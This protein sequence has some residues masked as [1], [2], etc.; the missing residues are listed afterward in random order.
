MKAGTECEVSRK[1]IAAN[2]RIGSPRGSYAI[3]PRARATCSARRVARRNT[4]KLAGPNPQPK[5]E[6]IHPF[7]QAEIDLVA[8]ELGPKLTGSSTRP[9]RSETT[10]FEELERRVPEIAAWVGTLPAGSRYGIVVSASETG[11]RPS[12][13]LAVHFRRAHWKTTLDAAGLPSRR[14]YDMRDS[15]AT[16]AL[17]VGLSIFDL[18]RYMGHDRGDDRPH[19]RALGAGRRGERAGEARRR[20]LATCGA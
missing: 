15:F 11:M 12:E 5:A 14:I 1:G 20:V 19:V 7:T 6:E 8:V 17:D 4:A 9:A 18:S 16:W 10:R 3:S 2:K 13:W